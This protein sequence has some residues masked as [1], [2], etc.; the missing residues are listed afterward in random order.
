MPKKKTLVTAILMAC[1]TFISSAQLPDYR[2]ASDDTSFL[3]LAGIVSKFQIIGLG[4]AAHGITTFHQWEY[5]FITYL[6]KN[7]RLKAFVLEDSY[8]KLKKIEDYV[9][10]KSSPDID[11]LIKHGLYSIWQSSDLV[12][13]I[14]F[15]H[16]YNTAATSENDRVHIMG[17]DMQNASGIYDVFNFFKERNQPL[18]NI[19]DKDLQLVAL[20]GQGTNYNFK[21]LPDEDKQRIKATIGFF[22]QRFAELQKDAS[23]AS[24]DAFLFALQDM[25]IVRQC[26][27]NETAGIFKWI[28]FRNEMLAKNVLWAQDHLAKG[29]GMV[30]MAHNGHVADASM[31]T[32]KYIKQGN[33]GYYAILEDFIDGDVVNTYTG[34]RDAVHAANEKKMFASWFS[35]QQGQL[36]F[37]DFTD[38]AFK[39]TPLHKFLKD[40][41]K[42]HE[43]G[44][45]NHGYRNIKPNETCN[46]VVIFRKVSAAAW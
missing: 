46:G 33:P 45:D 24:S 5:A 11:A 39:D 12:Q 20:L 31:T 9:Q 34:A 41:D 25:N 32:G 21:K 10:G 35:D 42:L 44:A 38:A 22:E 7:G 13:L 28:R 16:A 19:S 3:R 43:F 18:Q 23:I 26:Y 29:R 4:E 36:F 1:T 17:A 2:I 40:N 8:P 37:V 14:S 30:F 15:I 27:D 6:V